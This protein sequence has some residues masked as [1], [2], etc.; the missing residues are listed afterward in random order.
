MRQQRHPQRKRWQSWR[1]KQ[2]I[3]GVSQ[4]KEGEDMGRNEDKYFY[5][6]DVAI[7]KESWVLERFLMDL[8]DS[9]MLASPGKHL[10]VRLADYYKSQDRLLASQAS[11][12]SLE[13]EPEKPASLVTTTIESARRGKGKKATAPVVEEP[14]SADDFADVYDMDM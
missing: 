12:V 14:L 7:E 6:R 4:E 11:P 2:N 10:I 3:G 13:Q 5:L 8:K 1:T 9:S